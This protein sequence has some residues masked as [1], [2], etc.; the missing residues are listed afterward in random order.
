MADVRSA[1]ETADKFIRSFPNL[2]NPASLRLEETDT[3]KGSGDWLITVS[4]Q[5]ATNQGTL[6]GA[7]SGRLYKQIRVSKITNE[8]ISMKDR[9]VVKA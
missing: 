5:D 2:L 1:V 9:A 6:L 8:V 3:D 4:Y 7:V